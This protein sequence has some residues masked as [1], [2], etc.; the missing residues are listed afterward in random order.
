MSMRRKIT[1]RLTW[2]VLVALITG[3]SQ[4]GNETVLNMQQNCSGSTLKPTKEKLCPQA[5]YCFFYPE[6][7]W[8]TAFTNF[9]GRP[10]SLLS[11]GP[12]AIYCEI[13][14]LSDRLF[15]PGN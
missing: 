7:S 5:C 4:K 9:S 6:S 2:G 8:S 12:G 14:I 11:F 1:S 13:K 15:A 3:F 10:H